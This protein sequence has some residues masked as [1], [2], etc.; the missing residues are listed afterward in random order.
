MV[1]EERGSTLQLHLG[2]PLLP[3]LLLILPWGSVSWVSGF[4]WSRQRTAKL[5]RPSALCYDQPLTA[6]SPSLPSLTSLLA[7]P[8]AGKLGSVPERAVASQHALNL[9]SSPQVPLSD[10]TLMSPIVHA[11]RDPRDGASVND[12]QL[13]EST[14][15]DP[16]DTALT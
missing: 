14:W 8:S 5:R 15:T 7:S 16:T 6:P 3:E 11:P 12:P 13:W 1:C 2:L 9:P 10:G 4:P